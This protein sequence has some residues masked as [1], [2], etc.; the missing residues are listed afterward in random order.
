MTG[1]I[2]D[3]READGGPSS[4]TEFCSELGL[5]CVLPSMGRVGCPHDRTSF[6]VSCESC[7]FILSVV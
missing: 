5:V 6:L 3:E 1:G 2:R 4:C 7:S